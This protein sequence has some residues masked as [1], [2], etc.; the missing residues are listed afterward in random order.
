VTN[1]KF[2]V[3]G[4][5]S[6]ILYSKNPIVEMG[7]CFPYPHPQREKIITLVETAHQALGLTDGP[8]HTEVIVNENG[9]VEIIDLNPRFVGADVL[10]SINYAYGIKAQEILLDYAL[11]ENPVI[12]F[13]EN[14]YS[15]LQYFFPPEV[16]SLQSVDFPEGTEIKFHSQFIANGSKL[17]TVNRQIDYLGCYLTV[18]PSFSEALNRSRELRS[19]V[20]INGDQNGVF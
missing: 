10:Q 8:T 5:L 16:A 14:R 18:M 20:K 4:L 9:E 7:S 3:L 2:Q 1:G 15:C 6:R 17:S 12:D 19:Q 13:S 11:G